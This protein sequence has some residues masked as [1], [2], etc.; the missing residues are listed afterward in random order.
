MRVLYLA[1]R[2]PYAPNRGD[3]IRAYHSLRVL[4][5]AGIRTH[6]VALAHDDAEQSNA[7]RLGE[8]AESY[9][10]LRLPGWRNRIRAGLALAGS[11]P[12]THVLL[13]H[14]EAA[15]L[16]TARVASF[17]PHV[18]IAFCSGMAPLA[19]AP[20]VASLPFVLDIV[21]VDSAKWRDLSLAGP[22]PLRLVYAREARC[23]GRFER[24]ACERASAVLAINEREAAEVRA[25]CPTARVAVVP[26]GVDLDYFRRPSGVERRRQVVFTAVFNYPPNEVGAMWTIAEVWP[27]VLAAHPDA[28]LVLAGARPSAALRRAAKRAPRVTVT[29]TVDDIRPHLW[30]ASVA[31]APLSISRGTQ[32]KVLEAAASGLPCVVTSKVAEGLPS[33]VLQRCRVADSSEEFADAIAEALGASA[34]DSTSLEGLRWEST[35][36]PLLR[37]IYDL[38]T[39]TSSDTG[40][41]TAVAGGT[42][43]AFE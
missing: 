22:W 43:Q 31:I 36:A 15:A 1:H 30:S 11:T 17:K 19:L 7:G 39:A 20:D 32:N 5:E 21:D 40:E 33:V 2:V 25:L 16:L 9:D 13:D 18:V 4:R 8:V 28:E 12:L 6:V 34:S 27:R 41:A 23:L 26:N 37:Q 10:V 29:G 38:R 3:R 42:A 24:H 35:L 14:P